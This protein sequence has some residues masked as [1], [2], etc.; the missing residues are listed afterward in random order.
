MHECLHVC[1]CGVHRGHSGAY[2]EARGRKAMSCPIT[3]YLSPETELLNEPILQ[4][5]SAASTPV[6]CFTQ[7]TGVMGFYD[8]TGFFSVVLGSQAQVLLLV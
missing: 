4:V 2:A 1:V 6:V 3:L 8:H 5:G 7:P